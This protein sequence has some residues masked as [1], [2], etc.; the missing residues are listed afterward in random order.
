MRW[1]T[2]HKRAARAER[3][4]ASRIEAVIDLI[5]PSVIDAF[6]VAAVRGLPQ[7]IA[8]KEGRSVS[9]MFM[10][11]WNGLADHVLAERQRMHFWPDIVLEDLLDAE[12]L[13]E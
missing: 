9:P 4:E 3:D 13:G 10:T 12:F 5:M 7:F 2:H 6:V 11:Y 8:E 1:R